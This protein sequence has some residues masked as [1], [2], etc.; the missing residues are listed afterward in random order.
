MQQAAND[1]WAGKRLPA[2][3]VEGLFVPPGLKAAVLE[4]QDPLE[5]RAKSF[6]EVCG[7]RAFVWGRTFVCESTLDVW[8][9]AKQQ[10]QTRGCTSSRNVGRVDAQ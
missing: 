9:H 6:I 3:T 8:L 2:L 5:E 10:H 1:S 4:D 7:G